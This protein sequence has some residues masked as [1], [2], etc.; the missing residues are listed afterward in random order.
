MKRIKTFVRLSNNDDNDE[1]V[2]EFLS[3]HHINDIKVDVVN[4]FTYTSARDYV[5]YIDETFRPSIV[6]TII[7]EVKR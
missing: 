3:S 7:Y 2:N 6:T 5:S 1:E 4:G